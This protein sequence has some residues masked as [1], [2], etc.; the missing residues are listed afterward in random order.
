M[1]LVRVLASTSGAIIILSLLV[2]I[3]PANRLRWSS[4]TFRSTYPRWIISG[5]FGNFECGLTLE[6][7]LHSAT[8]VKTVGLLIGY[9]TRAAVGGTHCRQGSATILQTSLPWHVRY[10]SFTGALPSITS[11]STTI[12]GLQFNI[13]EPFFGIE[14][15]AS[16]G[17]ATGVYNREAGGVLTSTR[18]GG[19]SPT[20]CGRSATLEG[21]SN[22]LTVLNSTTRITVT[23]I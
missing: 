4:Q 6:G 10:E 1:K 15:L 18:I 5:G 12:T 22:S 23:L 2:S 19:E 7:S 9:I 21:T 3:S 13:K 20:S 16:G 14:C 8:I 11:F 17:I